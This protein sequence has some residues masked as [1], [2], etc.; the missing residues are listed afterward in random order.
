MS[1][2]PDLDENARS[3]FGETLLTAHARLSESKY[4]LT[5]TNDISFF[6][7]RLEQTGKFVPNAY[8]MTLMP[9]RPGEAHAFMLWDTDGNLAATYASRVYRFPVN[10]L[11]D[12][13]STLAL[14]YGNPVLQM[15]PG[16]RLFIEGDAFEHAQKFTDKVV[17]GGALWVRDDLRGKTNTVS[18]FGAAGLAMTQLKWGNI[19]TV[20]L[21]EEENYRLGFLR[22]RFGAREFYQGITWK[23]PSKPAREHI[24]LMVVPVDRIHEIALEYNTRG[25]DMIEL[26]RE[27]MRAERKA[28]ADGAGKAG[29]LVA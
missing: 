14:F 24:R 3:L 17:W 16:E 2:S 27:R 18:L 13:L 22:K 28:R 20:S 8:H 11:A 6:R 12:Y 23:R 26:D 29:Q 4:R 19:E 10:S 1:P 9:C 7:D 5:V 15:E 25:G 21:I